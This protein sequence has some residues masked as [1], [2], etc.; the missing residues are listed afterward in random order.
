MDSLEF[1]EKKLKTPSPGTIKAQT[2]S[3][4]TKNQFEFNVNKKNRVVATS[5]TNKDKS[6]LDEFSLIHTLLMV[7]AYLQLAQIPSDNI[8]LKNYELLVKK[9]KKVPRF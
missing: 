4:I 2:S 6:I 8:R 1:K 9:N 3:K 5:P 7:S